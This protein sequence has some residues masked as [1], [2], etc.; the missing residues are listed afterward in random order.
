MHTDVYSSFIHN[1]QILEATTMSFN[2]WMDKLLVH[3]YNGMLSSTK[4]HELSSNKKTRRDLKCILL[5]E[6]SQSE[7]VIYHMIL[8]IWHSGKGK[9][10]ETVKISVLPWAGGVGER[11]M[12]KWSTGHFKDSETIVYDIIMVNTCHFTFVKTDRMYNTKSKT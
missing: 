5:S 1:C 12:N 10:I 9:S 6:R 7:M 8:T 4:R 3:P 2:R 11:E